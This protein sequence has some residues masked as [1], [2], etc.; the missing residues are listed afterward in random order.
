VPLQQQRD[1]FAAR[2]LFWQA[3]VLVSEG[4]VSARLEQQFH[5]V[6]KLAGSGC[7]RIDTHKRVY[8]RSGEPLR[9]AGTAKVGSKEAYTLPTLMVAAG[10][11]GLDARTSLKKLH[12]FITQK[13]T[14]LL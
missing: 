12:L 5:D 7:K 9:A 11:L 1:R 4:G 3:A 13:H 2:H 14:V 6:Q 8:C 10:C